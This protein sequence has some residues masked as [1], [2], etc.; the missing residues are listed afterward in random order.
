MPPDNKDLVALA[1]VIQL[2]FPYSLFRY[3]NVTNTGEIFII[4]FKLALTSMILWMVVPADKIS[5][6][7]IHISFPQYK[8][9]LLII[10][11]A[12]TIHTGN[13]NLR[14]FSRLGTSKKEDKL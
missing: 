11:P 12:Q 5:T 7:C 8:C 13:S 10:N 1:F 9:S 14:P 2:S 4:L 3:V 6:L